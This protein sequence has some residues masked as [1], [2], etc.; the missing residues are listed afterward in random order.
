[1]SEVA[2]QEDA[3]ALHLCFKE[4]PLRAAMVG[5][6]SRA[7]AIDEVWPDCILH[8]VPADAR[9]CIGNAFKVLYR[10]GIIEQTGQWRNSRV[11]GQKGRR[12]WS[13]RLKSA[14]LATAFLRVNNVTPWKGQMEM[15]I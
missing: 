11:P 3:L 7:V 5:I 2:T 12:I 4:K 6:A 15:A 10:A 8:D 9:N 1:M 13:W 14:S